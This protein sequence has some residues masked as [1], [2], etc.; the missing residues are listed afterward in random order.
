[1]LKIVPQLLALTSQ[2]LSQRGGGAV[3]NLLF[4]RLIMFL[5]IEWACWCFCY[6][7]NFLPEQLAVPRF[8]SLSGRFDV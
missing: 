8:S 3:K 1:M 6:L 4:F 2:L 5:A 7:L